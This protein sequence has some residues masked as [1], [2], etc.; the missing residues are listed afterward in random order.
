MPLSLTRFLDTVDR[1]DNRHCASGND[2]AVHRAIADRSELARLRVLPER[3]SVQ[4]EK[5]EDQPMSQAS[6][7]AT[8]TGKVLA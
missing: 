7:M 2:C 1:H 6:S 5:N 8:R 4:S 3:G